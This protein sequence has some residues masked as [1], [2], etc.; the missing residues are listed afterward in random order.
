MKILIFLC[1]FLRGIASVI[2]AWGIHGFVNSKPPGRKMV[3]CQSNLYLSASVTC[4]ACCRTSSLIKCFIFYQVTADISVLFHLAGN[5]AV[6]FACIAACAR[7]VFGPLPFW[8]TFLFIEG[9]KVLA[10]A[11]IGLMNFSAFVQISIVSNHR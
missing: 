6:L 9:Y 2:N 3:S 8:L 1:S 4:L 7:A 11:I 10:V 5:S